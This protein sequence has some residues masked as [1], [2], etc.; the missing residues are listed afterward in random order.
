[1]LWF[2]VKINFTLLLQLFLLFQ[3]KNNVED[4]SSTSREEK[5]SSVCDLAYSCDLAIS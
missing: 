1:M 3:R 2:I 5:P 4:F